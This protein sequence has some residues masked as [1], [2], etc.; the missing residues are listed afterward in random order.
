[1]TDGPRGVRAR[2]DEGKDM[3]RDGHERGIPGEICVLMEFSS[4]SSSRSCG[5]VT[6]SPESRLATRY[7]RSC[8]HYE[9]FDIFKEL[10]LLEVP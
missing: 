2:E 7:V 10:L 8:M 6:D 5:T 4:C 1:V 3:N 9:H